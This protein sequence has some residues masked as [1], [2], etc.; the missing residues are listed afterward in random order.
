M[1]QSGPAGFVFLR[2]LLLRR[3]AISQLLILF[4]LKEN[5]RFLFVIS[6]FRIDLELKMKMKSVFVITKFGFTSFHTYS[7]ILIP[8]HLTSIYSPLYHLTTISF[9]KWI[10]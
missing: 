2:F 7:L 6:L 8:Y 3:T 9:Q 5:D 4:K 1:C 10:T